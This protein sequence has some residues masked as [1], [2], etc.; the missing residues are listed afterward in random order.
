MKICPPEAGNISNLPVE[1]E[2]IVR[3]RQQ[4]LYCTEFLF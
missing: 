2:Q 4:L 1:G 3:Q